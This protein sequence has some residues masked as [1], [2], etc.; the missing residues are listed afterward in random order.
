MI[1]SKD[2]IAALRKLSFPETLK[3]LETYLGLTG[4]LRQ[5]IPYYAQR[6]EPLQDRKTA[7]LRKG[8]TAG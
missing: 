6:T 1:S 8:P 4:W 2:R 3:D 7:L 5:Y